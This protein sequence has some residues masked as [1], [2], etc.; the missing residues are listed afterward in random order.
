MMTMTRIR[1]LALTGL[2]FP[3]L[4][5]GACDLGA[6]RLETRTFRV[7]NMRA[8]EAARMVE[9]YVYAER[10]EGSGGLIS[11]V[12]G[13]ITVRET[14]DNLAQIERVLAEFD[15]PR[16]DIRL[17]FQLIEADGFTG[18]DPSIADVEEEL[19]KLFRFQGYRLAGEATVAAA[20]FAN[21]DQL[22]RAGDASY[23]L[24]AH[25]S[26]VGPGATRLEDVM[27]VGRNV[28]LG[29]SVS[30]RE[31]QTVVLGSSPQADGTATLFLTVRALGPADRD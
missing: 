10:Q 9:P 5:L 25:V 2:S 7:E 1:A 21:I 22:I 26:R 19:R 20:D 27:L 24:T 11:V 8:E 30:V 15:V 16:A 29:T 3:T 23:S 31:G 14:S 18:S 17:H 13:A 4:A 6:P 12:D 28:Q